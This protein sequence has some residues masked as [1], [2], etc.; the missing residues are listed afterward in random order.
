MT[1]QFLPNYFKKV[2]LLIFVV[3]GIPSMKKGF[4]EGYKDA[5]GI[6][7]S[8]AFQAFNLFSITITEPIYNSLAIIGVAGLLMYLFSKDRVMD[9]FLVR[10]RLEAVQLTFIISALFIFTVLI[11]KSHWKVSAIG[12]IEYQVVLF[13][14]I[15]KVK[16]VMA[17]PEDGGDYE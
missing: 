13:L 11:F 8:D 2:G 16:K 5:Q 14:I 10:L 7:T 6:A 12:V 9:E 4:V 3:A 15:N 17:R 1:F